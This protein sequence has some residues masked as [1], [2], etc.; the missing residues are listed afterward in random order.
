MTVE[1]MTAA[2][3]AGMYWETYDDQCTDDFDF[4]GVDG[5]DTVEPLTDIESQAADLLRRYGRRAEIR[6][7]RR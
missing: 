2:D 7:Y 3:V 1:K 4:I 5:A 6:V